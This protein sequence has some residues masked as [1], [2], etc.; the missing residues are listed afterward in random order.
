MTHCS[1]VKP[2]YPASK[3]DRRVCN[4]KPD[5][6]FLHAALTHKTPR[7]NQREHHAGIERD[8][9]LGLNRFEQ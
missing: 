1:R 8:R 5:R 3:R 2:D 4:H 7:S 9:G 6:S